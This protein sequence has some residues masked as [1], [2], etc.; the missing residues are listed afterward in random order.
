MGQAED[1]EG[2]IKNLINFVQQRF[3]IKEVVFKWGGQH[4]KPADLLPYIGRKSKGSRQFVATGFATDGLVYGT[5]AAQIIAT[6][7][8][9][10]KHLYSDLF[11]AS[12]HSPGKAAKEF[13]KENADV[14]VEFVKGLF[15][16]E[17]KEMEEILPGEA[18]IIVKDNHKIAVHRSAKG[19]LSACS[20]ICTH[21]G[22][23][24]HF[25][26]AE[27]TWD[28]PCHGSRFSTRGDV[29]EGPALQP[30]KKLNELT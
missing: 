30:L 9:G 6:E 27:E 17:M 1:N 18:K 8:T 5:L 13:I 16:A 4:Y 20:A 7:L 25:N 12:R 26:N 23:V 15:T 19:I 22:C 29:I 3:R 10:T 14:A 21:M 28:C 2:Y 24:V 11:K